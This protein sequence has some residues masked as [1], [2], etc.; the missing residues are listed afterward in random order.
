MNQ[1]QDSETQDSEAGFTL[2]E[3]LVAFT[4]LA[5]AIIVSFQIFASGLRQQAAVEDRKSVMTIARTELDRLALQ[6]ALQDETR[7][8]QTGEVEWQITIK[9]LAG[10]SAPQDSL[11]RPFLVSFRQRFEGAPQASDP[12]LETVLLARPASP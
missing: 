2:V 4:I 3:T 10:N 6:P 9:A 11:L 5:G 7:L 1:T 12:L 8:G